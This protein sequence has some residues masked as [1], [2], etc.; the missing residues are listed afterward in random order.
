MIDCNTDGADV[1]V[2]RVLI[3]MGGPHR[4]GKKEKQDK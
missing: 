4:H 3:K 2:S 1:V